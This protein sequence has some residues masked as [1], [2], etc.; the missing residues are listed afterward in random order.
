MLQNLQTES[1]RTYTDSNGGLY[2]E[3]FVKVQANNSSGS[4]TTGYYMRHKTYNPRNGDE[5]WGGDDL[6]YTYCS[7]SS[8][9]ITKYSSTTFVNAGLLTSNDHS[10][11]M[12]ENNYCENFYNPMMYIL[13]NY[14]GQ[15]KS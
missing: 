12:I 13:K 15:A 11:G 9:N 4:L 10:I 5:G 7:S 8:S 6:W 1:S 14:N 2:Y 3:N